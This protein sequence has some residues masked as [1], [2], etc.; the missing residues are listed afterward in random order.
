MGR[1]EYG[2]GWQSGKPAVEKPRGLGTGWHVCASA[3]FERLGM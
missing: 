3:A 1:W 2:N